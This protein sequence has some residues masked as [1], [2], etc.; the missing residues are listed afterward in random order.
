M[1]R[2]S[3]VNLFKFLENIW[4]LKIINKDNKKKLK[5]NL[6]KIEMKYIQEIQNFMNGNKN[7]NNKEKNDLL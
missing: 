3:K 5:K 7:N 1:K 4:V 6:I 2:K